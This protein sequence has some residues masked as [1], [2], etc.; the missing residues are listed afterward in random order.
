MF[1]LE[2]HLAAE[3]WSIV[4]TRTVILRIGLFRLIKS[5]EKGSDARNDED[6]AAPRTKTY[7]SKQTQE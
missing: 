5:V 7:A 3:S 1:Y 4:I 2:N 6:C